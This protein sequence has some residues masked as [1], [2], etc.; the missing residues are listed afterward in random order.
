MVCPKK[1]HKIFFCSFYYRT[2]I[3]KV[4]NLSQVSAK[5]LA[6]TEYQ[7]AIK[8]E[9]YLWRVIKTSKDW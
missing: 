3:V 4:L 8:N 5:Q 2:I 6:K 7:E 1:L 9:E